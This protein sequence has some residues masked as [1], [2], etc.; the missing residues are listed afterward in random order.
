MPPKLAWIPET[1]SMSLEVP[2]SLLPSHSGGHQPMLKVLSY[3][4]ATNLEFALCLFHIFTQTI[5]TGWRYL[6][7]NTLCC[8]SSPSAVVFAKQN[9]VEEVDLSRSFRLEGRPILTSTPQQPTDII[10][11]R[12]DSNLPPVVLQV[13]LRMRTTKCPDTIHYQKLCANHRK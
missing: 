1:C 7:H 9:L 3:G 6:W 10:G 13:F 4:S 2:G 5:R 12:S 11:G 8:G